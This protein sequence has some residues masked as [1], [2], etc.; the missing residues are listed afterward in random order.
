MQFGGVDITFAQV[1]LFFTLEVKGNC[2]R[3]QKQKTSHWHFFFNSE[4][5]TA[6]HRG[7]F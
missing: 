2:R 3:G 6:I 4:S 1:L 5:A 7:N